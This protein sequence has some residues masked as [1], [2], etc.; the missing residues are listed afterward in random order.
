M[1]A[2]RKSNPIIVCFGCHRDMKLKRRCYSKEN[3]EKKKDFIE[4]QVDLQSKLVYRL[5]RAHVP[6]N[7][8]QAMLLYRDASLRLGG[9][10]KFR[11]KNEKV[12]LLQNAHSSNV[13]IV[14][15]IYNGGQMSCL[16]K[17]LRLW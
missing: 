15:H 16:P 14:R 12:K 2:N 1:A 5:S 3:W 17:Y 7:I 9:E 6:L 10:E 11:E 8:F 4:V 13:D